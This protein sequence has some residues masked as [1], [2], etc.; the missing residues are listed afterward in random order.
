MLEWTNGRVPCLV[1]CAYLM[2]SVLRYHMT[3]SRTVV[4]N[5]Q[6]TTRREENSAA[7]ARG[8]VRAKL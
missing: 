5:P 7:A 1:P 4:I 2:P 3:G 6:I 8:N